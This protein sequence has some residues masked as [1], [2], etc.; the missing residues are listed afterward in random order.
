MR[1]D[2]VPMVTGVPPA[3]M[4]GS[5][6]GAPVGVVGVQDT[7]QSPPDVAGEPQLSVGVLR[8]VGAPPEAGKVS[9]T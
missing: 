3:S 8:T 1:A 4:T 5:S 6:H 9:S 7:S 2:M